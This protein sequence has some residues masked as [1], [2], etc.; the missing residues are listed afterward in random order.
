MSTCLDCELPIRS[1]RLESSPD[2]RKKVL[3]ATPKSQELPNGAKRISKD[4]KNMISS[5]ASPS[6][7]ALQTQV[8]TESHARYI[9][10]TGNILDSQMVELQK[11]MKIGDV[12][13]TPRSFDCYSWKLGSCVVLVPLF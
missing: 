13:N 2:D 7:S 5:T 3:N 8:K 9:K 1:P 10:Y 11:E 4:I 6:V 12:S